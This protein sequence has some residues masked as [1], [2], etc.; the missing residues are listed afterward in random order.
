M[1]KIVTPFELFS[2]SY[3]FLLCCFNFDLIFK[4]SFL[5]LLQFLFMCNVFTFIF[6]FV[7]MG[8]ETRALPGR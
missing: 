4:Y 2:L 8:F 1:I 5:G 3:H 6:Y 7:I